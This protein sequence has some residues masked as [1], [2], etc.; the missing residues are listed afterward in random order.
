VLD[1]QQQPVPVGVP[2]ELYVAGVGLARGYLNRPALTAERFVRLAL[3]GQLPTGHGLPTTVYRTGD[4]VRYRADGNLEFLGRID[5]QVKLRGFRIELAEIEA[6]LRQ[7][8]G[9]QEGVVLALDEG[10][11]RRLVAYLVPSGEA[12]PPLEVLRA[13][14]R[15]TLPD[16]MVPNLFVPLAALPLSP[17]GKIDRQALPAPDKARPELAKALVL[18]RSETEAV[19]AQL[20]AELLDLEQVGVLDNFFELGGHSL[21]ATQLVSRIHDQLHVELPVKALFETPTVAGLAQRIDASARSD[22]DLARP[23]AVLAR[24]DQ[25]SEAEV[26]ALLAEKKVTIE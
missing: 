13:G 12:L 22:G 10:G 3:N 17:S 5:H 19:L 14:L 15:R 20:W 18:P 9:V 23:E 6:A 21:L 1:G 16:Y 8:P 4:L 11:D 24:V 2:G 7:Q 25:L 26:L